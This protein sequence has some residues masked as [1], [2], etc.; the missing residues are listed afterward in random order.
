MSVNLKD[1]GSPPSSIFDLDG[2]DGIGN[3]GDLISGDVAVGSRQSTIPAESTFL[4]DNQYT[5]GSDGTINKRKVDIGETRREGRM[6]WKEVYE[7]Q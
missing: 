2:I 4:G 3:A 5:P 6:S 1:G 7:A